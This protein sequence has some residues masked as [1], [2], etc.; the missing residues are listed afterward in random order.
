MAMIADP[1]GHSHRRLRRRTLLAASTSALL[2]IATVLTTGT[3]TA[4]AAGETVNVWLTSTNDSGGRNVTR[5]LQQQTPISFGA[6]GSANQTITVDENP[7]YHQFTAPAPS[8]THPAP[9]L[10][11]STQ[12]L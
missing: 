11:N 1:T 7:K 5:G 2:M 8:F 10:M 4:H 6:G 12:P 9:S 3:P